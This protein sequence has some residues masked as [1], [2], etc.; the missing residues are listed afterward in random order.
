MKALE[1]TRAYWEEKQSLVDDFLS[2]LD[3]D[4]DTAPAEDLLL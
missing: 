2:Q 4:L 1:L 3:R